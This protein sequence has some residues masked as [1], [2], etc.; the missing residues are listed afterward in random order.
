MISTFS[1]SLYRLVMRAYPA[2]FRAQY[3]EAVDQA[4]RDNVR[5]AARRP[6]GLALLWFHIVPDFLFS[7]GELLLARA[8]DFL[9]WRFRLQWVVACSLGFALSRCV[10]LV[11]GPEFFRL[12]TDPG[13]SWVPWGEMVGMTIRLAC[14]GWLQ[15]LVLAGRCFRRRQW[16]L[17][18]IAGA[19]LTTLAVAPLFLVIRPSLAALLRLTASELGQGLLSTLLGSV[20]IS[21]PMIILGAFIGAL[22]S[23]AIKSDAVTRYRWMMACAAGYFLSGVTGGFAI[24]VP[25]ISVLEIVMTS[26]AS[27]AALG[28]LTCG[29]L[30]RILLGVQGSS[31]ENV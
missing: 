22:Q 9:K 7:F 3:G 17:Y 5:D 14:L 8:G 20:L 12:P 30:E 1:I 15:S 16:V 29:P 23:A 13:E 31:K 6:L 26:A 19:V 21:A 11:I 2:D 18:G 10:T 27:G 24:P 4:F 25:V 28:L